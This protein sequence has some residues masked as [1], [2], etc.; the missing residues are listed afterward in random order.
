MSFKLI[1]LFIQPELHCIIYMPLPPVGGKID[2]FPVL[3]E[4]AI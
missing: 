4:P 1:C 3:K 2:L